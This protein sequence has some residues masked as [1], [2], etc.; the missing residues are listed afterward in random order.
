MA[1]YINSRP[2]QLTGSLYT[3]TAT[4]EAQGWGEE[5]GFEGGEQE[6]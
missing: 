5:A 6:L 3:A 2:T 4:S 1:L